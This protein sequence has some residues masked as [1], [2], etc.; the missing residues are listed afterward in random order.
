VSEGWATS[1]PPDGSVIASA[2]IASPARIAGITSRRTCS[3]APASTG[4]S[5]IV[6]EPRPAVTPPM[7]PRASSIEDSS[8]VTWSTGVPP[9]SAG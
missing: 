3:R 5:M 7:P 9:Y 1:E 6:C 4:H 8:F 2:P